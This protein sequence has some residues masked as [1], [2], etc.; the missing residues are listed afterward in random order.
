MN[1]M[2]KKATS[3]TRNMTKWLLIAAVF[4]VQGCA[5]V[6]V[7]VTGSDMLTQENADKICLW[8]LGG[9]V[10]MNRSSKKGEE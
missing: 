6:D 2:L 9:S 8:I 10:A 5:A 1:K 4:V 7:Q 3:D